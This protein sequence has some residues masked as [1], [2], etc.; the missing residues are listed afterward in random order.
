MMWVGVRILIFGTFVI[1]VLI[2]LAIKTINRDW[3]S[4]RRTLLVVLLMCLP[5]W[6]LSQAVHPPLRRF[7]PTHFANWS[8]NLPAGTPVLKAGQ[9]LEEVQQVLGCP[10]GKY[11]NPEYATYPINDIPHP[12]GYKPKTDEELVATHRLW[13]DD[14]GI[15]DCSFNS[16]DRLISW[17]HTGKWIVF[18]RNLY[19]I[20]VL[21]WFG[22]E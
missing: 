3:K 5:W 9:S 12:M 20:R 14:Q 19:L 17:K 2:L 18:E 7:D 11:G 16:E 1:S 13:E 6:F 8:A 15:L 22:M 21:R 4:I 10:P